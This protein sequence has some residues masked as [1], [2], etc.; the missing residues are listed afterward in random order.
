MRDEAIIHYKTALRVKP[1]F[2]R[3]HFNLGVSYLAMNLVKE[4]RDEFE[5][6]LKSDPSLLQARQFLEYTRRLQ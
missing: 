4:A 3:A 2:A 6:A 5:A 1:D